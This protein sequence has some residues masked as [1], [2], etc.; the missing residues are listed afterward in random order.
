M[1]FTEETTNK[2]T[3][4]ICKICAIAQKFKTKKIL[5]MLKRKVHDGRRDLF[6]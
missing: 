2:S 1:L 6:R 4:N 3:E 5:K